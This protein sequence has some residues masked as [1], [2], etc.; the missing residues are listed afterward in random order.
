MSPEQIRQ[1]CEEELFADLYAGIDNFNTRELRDTANRRNR[2][3]E[4]RKNTPPD[5][6][7]ENTAFEEEENESYSIN[8][9]IQPDPALEREN[10]EAG[11]AAAKRLMEEAQTSDNPESLIA[12]NAMQRSDIG[13]IDFRWGKPGTGSKFKGGYGL[14][15]IIEN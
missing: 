10:I 2:T 13:Y 4:E 11:K 8:T 15:H 12:K 5:L 14:A 6:G 7:D 1:I 3:A 9:G